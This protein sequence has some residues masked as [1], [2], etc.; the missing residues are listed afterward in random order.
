MTTPPNST[1]GAV[2]ARTPSA[3]AAET[4]ASAPRTT[5]NF[6]VTF[7]LPATSPL[8]ALDMDF[9]SN[10]ITVLDKSTAPF[11]CPCCRTASPGNV[12]LLTSTTGRQFLCHETLTPVPIDHL[13]LAIAFRWSDLPANLRANFCAPTDADLSMAI[14]LVV[15]QENTF[16]ETLVTRN[17]SINETTEIPMTDPDVAEL[18]NAD[19]PSMT[20][21]SFS[22]TP[23]VPDNE[24]AQILKSAGATDA[25]VA[26]TIK[27]MTLCL[28]HVL[29]RHTFEL[30]S[31]IAQLERSLASRPSATAPSTR[32]ETSVTPTFSQ[33]FTQTPTGT[34]GAPTPK[35]S[36][37][38]LFLQNKDRIATGQGI[39]RP[40]QHYKWVHLHGFAEIP[41][42]MLRETVRY[43]D[44]QSWP[45]TDAYFL[46]GLN[47]WELFI[48]S[49]HEQSLEDTFKKA[50]RK[51]YFSVP[52]DISTWNIDG[53]TSAARLMRFDPEGVRVCD[54][55]QRSRWESID[56]TLRAR[57][58][59]QAKKPRTTFAVPAQPPQ[60]ATAPSLNQ[61]TPAPSAASPA[62]DHVSNALATTTPAPSPPL[63]EAPAAGGMVA[64]A[65]SSS[66]P[67]PTAASDR[68]PAAPSL[69]LPAATP[70]GPETAAQDYEMPQAPS[71]TKPKHKS[72]TSVKDKRTAAHSSIVT[73]SKAAAMSKSLTPAE[74]TAL[75]LSA[76]RSAAHETF[77]PTKGD[78]RD[79]PGGPQ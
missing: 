13:R 58:A 78:S 7:T 72:V 37:S 29:R 26:C 19:T 76:D 27:Y 73:R 44:G 11:E 59:N 48:K 1:A 41:V 56:R 43:F 22:P 10:A 17:T 63:S 70:T 18:T 47:V 6:S 50:N 33:L 30:E 55:L 20:P 39:E 9:M 4:R 28:S 79:S 75:E 53:L 42:R 24:L 68:P 71:G 2:P 57:E 49:S 51:A 65:F 52:H 34:P 21:V 38:S 40:P 62:S 36:F 46:R 14:D 16:T 54:R 31:R 15:G 12:A 66:T 35:P 45:I 61:V 60:N 64:P 25:E 77:S 5:K 74:R 67:A 69:A 8:R 3:T 32:T 23:S